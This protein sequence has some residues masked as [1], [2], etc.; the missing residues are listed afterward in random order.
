[1]L[2][3]NSEKNYYIKDFSSIKN[4]SDNK[5]ITKITFVHDEKDY[6][7]RGDRTDLEHLFEVMKSYSSEI[8]KDVFT[9][10]RDQL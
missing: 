4:K 1:M 9:V 5:G 3:Q 2:S 10:T 7:I 6:T 8:P